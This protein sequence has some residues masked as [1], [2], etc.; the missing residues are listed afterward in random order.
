MESYKLLSSV[1]NDDIKMDIINHYQR[2]QF[3]YDFRNF[4]IL[5]D[6]INRDLCE[7]T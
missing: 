2:Y 1:K 3:L 4:M 7:H 6:Y 5:Y